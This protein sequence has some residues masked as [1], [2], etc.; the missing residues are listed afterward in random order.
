LRRKDVAVLLVSDLEIADK[1]H[2]IVSKF[3][4]KRCCAEPPSGHLGD[5]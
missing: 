4:E 1:Q 2:N 3:K 5:A